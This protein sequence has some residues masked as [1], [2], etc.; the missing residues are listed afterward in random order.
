MP[1]LKPAT[2]DKIIFTKSL[3]HL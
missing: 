3:E 1:R 2:D